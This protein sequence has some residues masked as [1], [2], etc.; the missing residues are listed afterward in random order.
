[1]SWKSRLEKSM[2]TGAVIGLALT[3]FEA[4]RRH[5]DLAKAAAR[6]HG[7]HPSVTTTLMTGF[8]ATTVAAGMVVF[9]IATLVSLRWRRR[10]LLRS[11]T[12]R[13]YTG[14]GGYGDS[15]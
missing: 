14:Y 12:R 3:L 13:G 4:T 8:V 5:A 10:S 11:S 1:M 2:F 7:H 6:A 9:V 15:W